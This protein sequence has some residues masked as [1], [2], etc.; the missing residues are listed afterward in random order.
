MSE[1]MNKHICYV[2]VQHMSTG[3][4]QLHVLLRLSFPA[5]L[6]CHLA[7]ALTESWD[8][9]WSPGEMLLEVT[10]PCLCLQLVAVAAAAGV[11]T[12]C[13]PSSPSSRSLITAIRQPF[14]C[15]RSPPNSPA[16]APLSPSRPIDASCHRDT[17]HPGASSRWRRGL[18]CLF[19]LRTV[20]SAADHRHL[21]SACAVVL[22]AS[23]ALKPNSQTQFQVFA[24][25]SLPPPLYLP[26]AYSALV[27]SRH[28]PALI[29]ETYFIATRT[30]A[31]FRCVFMDCYRG[32]RHYLT[33]NYIY[34]PKKK[35]YYYH[36][37]LRCI[38]LKS[39]CMAGK[40]IIRY[41][42]ELK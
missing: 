15:S 42:L 27:L 41:L 26:D 31:T 22:L 36:Y 21:V 19:Y 28:F 7:H 10:Y 16:G 5:Q 23:A 8:A 33:A 11:S 2:S 1:C 6:C 18:F 20:Q 40:T 17:R 34:Q 9:P 37:W 29:C 25:A 12:S 13:A 24:S 38:E 30:P 4:C 35:H 32:C 14:H 39:P 3:E